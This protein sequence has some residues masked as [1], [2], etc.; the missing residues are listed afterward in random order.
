MDPKVIIIGGGLA[1]SE[2]AWQLAEEGVSV[3]LYEMRP[4]RSTP[5]HKTGS[6]AELVC[7][8]SFRS[9]Q[10]QNAVGLLKEE[11]GLLGSLIMRCALAHRVPA[12][13]A[14]ALD[15]EGFAQAVTQALAKHPRIEVCRE[16]IRSLTELRE[17]W[18]VPILLATGPLTSDALSRAITSLTQSD[19]LYFYD[20][21]APIVEAESINLGIAFRASRYGKGSADYLNCPLNREEYE[22]FVGELLNAEKV[23]IKEFDQ[24]KFFEGCLPVEVMA[25]RSPRALSFGPMKPVGLTDPRTGKRPYAVVQLRRD[26]L[27]GNLYNLVGFQTRMKYPEQKRIFRMIPGLENAEFVRLGSMHRNTF[28][29]SPQLLTPQLELRD[30]PGIYFAGQMIGVEGY[31]ESSAMGLYA[32]LALAQALQGKKIAPPTPR[33][34]LG[35]L[36]RHVTEANPKGFQPMNVNFGIFEIPQELRRKDHREL[37]ARKSLEEIKAWNPKSKDSWITSKTKGNTPPIPLKTTVTT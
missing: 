21:I 8:N 9:A 25:E 5:A 26:D 28:I 36:I 35:A 11:M 6:L 30:H 18:K 10:I 16:E 34:A 22:K 4:V 23:P 12:G 14:L 1:G 24:P 19:Y 32:G 2:A 15:R 17:E 33:T 3:R 31:V 20:S 29:N 7:S 27:H 13:S 37:L